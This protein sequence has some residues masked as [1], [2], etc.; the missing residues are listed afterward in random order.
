MQLNCKFIV[1][2]IFTTVVLGKRIPHRTWNNPYA[3]K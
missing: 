2:T 1:V 3:G